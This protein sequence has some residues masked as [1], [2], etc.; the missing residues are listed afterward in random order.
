MSRLSSTKKRRKHDLKTLIDHVSSNAHLEKENF[1]MLDE[2]IDTLC[3]SWWDLS[4]ED[5]MLIKK[6]QMAIDKQ[7]KWNTE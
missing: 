1:Q 2:L 3:K 4:S 6:A 5:K 7:T